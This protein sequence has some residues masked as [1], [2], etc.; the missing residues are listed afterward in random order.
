M[1][2][3]VIIPCYNNQNTIVETIQSVIKQTHKSIE[4]I[5]VNDGSIDGSLQKISE[6]ITNQANIKLINQ[7]NQGPS[8]SRN[9]GAEFANGKYLVFLDADDLLH[10]TYVE[11]CVAYFEKNP[12]TNIVYSNAEFFE[13]KTGKWKLPNFKIDKFLVINSIPIFATIRTEH[14]KDVKGFDTNLHFMEDMELWIRIIKKFGDGVYKIPET[15]FYYRKSNNKTSLTDN[16]TVNRISDKSLLY[17]Y[18]KH[19]EF[20]REYNLDIFNIL[21]NNKYKEKYYSIWYKKMFYIFKTKKH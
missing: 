2:V 17:I 19:Y 14:F 9:N 16:H 11:K 5:I 12:K 13:A 8:A 6:F 4:L 3:S 21:R 1:L 10:E 20:Y 7:A 18:N 15:L